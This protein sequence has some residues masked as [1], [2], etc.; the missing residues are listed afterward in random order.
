MELW[1]A[2]DRIK[3]LF[4]YV[5]KPEELYEGVFFGKGT[6]EISNDLFPE[7]TYENS[8]QKVKLELINNKVN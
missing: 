6:L 5:T 1:I 4:L 8:P 2:R 7:I 3:G